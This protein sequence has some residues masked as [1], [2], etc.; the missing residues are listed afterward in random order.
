MQVILICNGLISWWPAHG[1]TCLC[2]CVY[3]WVYWPSAYQPP[4]QTTEL[5]TRMHGLLSVID[6]HLT[7]KRKKNLK[8]YIR[9]FTE[10]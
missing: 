1:L 8:Y 3:S 9:N 6:E 2:M 10:G 7:I 5:P 4:M